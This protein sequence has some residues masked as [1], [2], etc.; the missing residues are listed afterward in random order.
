MYVI[1]LLIL[2]LLM[3]Q[4]LTSPNEVTTGPPANGRPSYDS[5]SSGGSGDDEEMEAIM[6]SNVGGNHVTVTS[7][8][9]MPPPPSLHTWVIHS[10]IHYQTHPRCI[11]SNFIFHSLVETNGSRLKKKRLKYRERA[12]NTEAALLPKVA[13]SCVYLF[14]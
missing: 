3:L 9:S 11:H 2:L 5:L 1:Y 10:F 14:K 7:I 4:V 13:L 8:R 12:L 6:A